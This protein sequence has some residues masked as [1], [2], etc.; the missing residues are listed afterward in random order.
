MNIND[1]F[2]KDTLILMGA[3]CLT[4]LIPIL[5]FGITAG[6][7]PGYYFISYESFK[8][9]INGGEIYPRWLSDINA[10]YGGANFYFYHPFLFYLFYLLDA[11]TFFLLSTNQLIAL[12]ITLC[13]FLSGCSFYIFAQC[14]TN[15]KFALV[16]ALIYML[17]P[18]HFWWDL[19]E[20]KALTEFAAYIWVPLIF[21]FL[22]TS[23]LKNP[24]TMAG[25]SLSYAALILTHLPTALLTSIAV[26]FYGLYQSTKSGSLSGFITFNIKLGFFSLLGIGLSTIY[27]LPALSLLEHV[28]YA[29]LWTDF[30]DYKNHFIMPAG[31]YGENSAYNG[32]IVGMPGY[33]FTLAASQLILCVI[34]FFMLYKKPDLIGNKDFMLYSA[35]ALICFVMMNPI[36]TIIWE[37]FPILQRVQFTWRIMVIMDF[38]TLALLCS[39]FSQRFIEATFSK[40]ILIITGFILVFTTFTSVIF[41]STLGGLPSQE[42]INFR[43]EIKRLTEEHIPV[44]NGKAVS[45]NDV[46][47]FR[48]PEFLVVT[49]GVAET[50]YEPYAARHFKIKVKAQTPAT[51]QVRQFMFPAWRIIDRFTGDVSSHQYNLRATG[52]FGLMTFDVPAGEHNLEIRLSYFKEEYHGLM[53]SVLSL[54]LLGIVIVSRLVVRKHT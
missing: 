11:F 29:Y 49:S 12:G 27:L 39:I 9:H 42:A 41:I 45:L 50:S 43:Y 2:L 19:Y 21:Y 34:I 54:L 26:L 51:I 14:Y 13:L 15:A 46:L 37:A 18:Y 35:L 36:S 44:N 17:L 38:V 48:P 7:D 6:H 32:E 23:I 40:L 1:G 30:Y 31:T 16:F 5:I 10:G 4:A 52:P 25:Y 53:I 20:R 24:K 47:E 8:H 22:N 33:L 3:A 28:N